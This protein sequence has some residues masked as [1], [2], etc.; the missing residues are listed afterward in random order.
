MLGLGETCRSALLIRVPWKRGGGWVGKY[1][2]I[3]QKILSPFF[4]RVFLAMKIESLVF[5]PH[6]NWQ[7]SAFLDVTK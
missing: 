3:W 1:G 6:E 4:Y 7:F 2:P 5:S